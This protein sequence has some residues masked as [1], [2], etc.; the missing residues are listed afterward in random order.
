MAS[1]QPVI[2]LWEI[3]DKTNLNVLSSGL[4]ADKCKSLQWD[5][6]DYLEN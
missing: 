1:N 5:F 4:F 3:T 6:P 2:K